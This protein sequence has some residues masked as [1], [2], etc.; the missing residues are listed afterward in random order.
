MSLLEGRRQ[1][2]VLDN[3]EQ[4]LPADA[5]LAA[6]LGACPG[7]ALLVTS[8]A[9][10]RLHAAQTL[11][12]APLP[13]PTA[14]LAPL[15]EL[16]AVPSVALFVQRARRHRADF[17]LAAE[18]A[19][20]VARLTAELDGLPLA[21]ELAA[22]RTTTLPLPVLANRLGDRL[23]LLRWD[24]ADLPARQ[25]SLEAAIGWS[26]DLLDEEEQRLFRCLGVFAGRVLPD[27][28]ADVVGKVRG[29]AED[30]NGGYARRTLDRLVELAEQSLLVPVRTTDAGWQQEDSKQVADESD[31]EAQPTFG[32]LQ[33]VREYAEERL[34][35]AGELEAARRAHAHVF[36][37][38][39]ERA[40]SH[41]LGPPQCA[42]FLRLER[43]HDNLC[44]A[45]RWLLD[46]DEPA[47][48]ERALRL[49]G[50]L[51]PFWVWYGHH[52]EGIR[53]LEEALDCS[54]TGSLSGARL[55][56]GA[57][58][59]IP[60]EVRAEGEV[61]GDAARE[62][63]LRGAGELL[64]LRGDF[65]RA[66]ARLLEA[67]DMARQRRDP[68]GVVEA[69]AYLGLCEVYA[70]EAAT[71]IPL[72][73]EAL[74]EAREL[75]EPSPLGLALYVMGV[76]AHAQG[77]TNDAEAHY[78]LALDRLTAAGDSLLAGVVH[79]YL[80]SVV[81]HRGD[82]GA[83]ARH[84]QVALKGSAHLHNTWLLSY[85]ARVAG[86]GPYP[87][88]PDPA[89]LARLVG[90]A[91]ALRQATGAQ[92]VLWMPF[93]EDE[94]R[95]TLGARLTEEEQEAA[96]REGRSLSPGE[97]IRIALHVLDEVAAD[98]SRSP[99]YGPTPS[100]GRSQNSP[101][102]AVPTTSPSPAASG[103]HN[104][105]S[106]REREVLRLVAQ[107]LGNKAIARQLVISAHT[108]NYHLNQIF[109][110]LGVDT[111]AQAV[112]LAMRQGLL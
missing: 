13:V 37:A 39:A 108:V 9:P 58:S 11:Y 64:A 6:L 19:P 77:H 14:P 55:R 61:T 33:T 27:T 107:G 46:Q 44:A 2:L 78:T 88:S 70:G 10:L 54:T 60:V 100:A 97:V 52:V 72:V 36:L 42:W 51:G 84:V 82:L 3:F 50:A 8:R 48:R 86:L 83:A 45:L 34:A 109:D 73:Q 22:A 99:S 68:S 53:W 94:N 32:M 15:A 43:E 23:H 75:D 16:E 69:L 5:S 66:R 89:E 49:A 25:R 63:A 28:I 29:A 1:L 4:V 111:R 21:L 90:A 30:T 106:A 65:A 87:G 92:L 101:T 17:V 7:L 38:L 81:A 105:L 59:P 76:A 102:G 56:G 18:Q 57:P 91:D 103:T 40:S 12:I 79:L 93:D 31:D 35:A 20:V 96:Y 62:H 74:R 24:A 47:E 67:L 85:C 71:A 110:K 112:A 80:A 95:G 98:A 104:A 41:L 26:Y